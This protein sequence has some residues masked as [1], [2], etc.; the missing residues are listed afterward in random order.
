MRNTH[1]KS[2]YLVALGVV[3]LM[4]M[5]VLAG[6]GGDDDGEMVEMIGDDVGEMEEM[7]MP[8]PMGYRVTITNNLA[9]EYSL[10]RLS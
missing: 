2:P 9:D 3:A 8:E 5:L 10:P 6:C 1:Q 7:M 4:A